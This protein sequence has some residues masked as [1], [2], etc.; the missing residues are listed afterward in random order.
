M[1]YYEDPWYLAR[2]AKRLRGIKKKLKDGWE[3]RP[4]ESV[5]RVFHKLG[6]VP[7]EYKGERKTT[8]LQHERPL[9]IP[10]GD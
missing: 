2:G 10:R 9:E 5:Q 6:I 8:S 3:T 1:G 7:S 4:A